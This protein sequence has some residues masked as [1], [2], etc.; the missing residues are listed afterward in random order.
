MS[1]SVGVLKS[2]VMTIL[3]VDEVYEIIAIIK[4]PAQIT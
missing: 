2:A 1:V 4:T 3:A